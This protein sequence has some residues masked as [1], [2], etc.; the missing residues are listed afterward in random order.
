[1]IRFLGRLF[2]CLCQSVSLS[3]PGSR[4]CHPFCVI[5]VLNTDFSEQV[6]TVGVGSW[7]VNSTDYT[8]VL[9]LYA[10]DE[11]MIVGGLFSSLCQSVF[12][13]IQCAVCVIT[14]V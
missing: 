4:N 2:T 3:I 7:Q 12:L 5:C 11:K 9:V 14:S 1:M 13:T 8:E 10:K 6:A